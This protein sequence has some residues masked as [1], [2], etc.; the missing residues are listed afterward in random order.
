M[1]EMPKNQLACQIT[2]RIRSIYEYVG[3]RCDDTWNSHFGSIMN[4]LESSSSP[5]DGSDCPH[6]D[7]D[8]VY[9]P[10]GKSSIV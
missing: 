6:I 3:Q 5:S 10:A 1:L 9:G 7:L 2:Q 4:Q 8:V